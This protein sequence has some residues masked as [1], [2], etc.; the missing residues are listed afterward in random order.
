MA[1]TLSELCVHKVAHLAA[2]E[3][4]ETTDL[5]AVEPLSI[6]NALT[7]LP[8]HQAGMVMLFVLYSFEIITLARFKP[9]C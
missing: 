4:E 7:Y 5:E 2:A 3:V 9:A 6:I 1:L 8:N